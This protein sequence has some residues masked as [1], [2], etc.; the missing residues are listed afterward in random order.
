[1][2]PDL[3]ADNVVA[4]LQLRP[5]PE[6][7][8]YRETFRDEVTD[9]A[10][11]SA[12]TAILYLL[13]SGES[14]ARHRIDATE[15]WHHYAGAALELTVGDVTVLLGDDLAAGQLPQVV[16][17]AAAWQSARPLGAWTLAGCTVAPGFEFDGF[18]L[19]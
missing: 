12:S 15:V 11:R 5:H 2:T 9:A 18:Q 3:T 14:S 4:L 16:V 17:P 13:A 10:G 1:M 8:W 19:A 6:G 7:G